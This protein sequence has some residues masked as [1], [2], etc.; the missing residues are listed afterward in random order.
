MSFSILSSSRMLIS[1]S[2]QT[3]I[4]A[5]GA[6]LGASKGKEIGKYTEGYSGYVHMA[7]DSVSSLFVVGTLFV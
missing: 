2:S 4:Y 6:G 7:Q 3:A 1:S 5:Q